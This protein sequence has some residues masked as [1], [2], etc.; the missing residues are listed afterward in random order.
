MSGTILPV[1]GKRGATVRWTLTT[2]MTALRKLE[3]APELMMMHHP[4]HH[5]RSYL[6][7]PIYSSSSFIN[8]LFS[9]LPHLQEIPPLFTFYIIL[10]VCVCVCLCALVCV[11]QNYV[12]VCV[13]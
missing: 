1:Y 5:P 6:I 7:H 4:S 9:K 8:E 3:S 11:Y 10:V 2:E 13:H 12:C